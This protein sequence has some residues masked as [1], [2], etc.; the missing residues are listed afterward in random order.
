MNKKL[1]EMEKRLMVKHYWSL[2]E[3]NE[4][5]IFVD[6]KLH[7][8]E[9][10]PNKQLKEFFDDAIEHFNIGPEY[11]TLTMEQEM[12]K[13]LKNNKNGIHDYELYKNKNFKWSESFIRQHKDLIDFK[14]LGYGMRKRNVHYSMNLYR[15]IADQKDVGEFIASQARV[16]DCYGKYEIKEI[17]PEFKAKVAKKVNLDLIKEFRKQIYEYYSDHFGMQFEDLR[18]ELVYI[19]KLGGVII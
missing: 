1:T 3:D 2:L 8:R 6:W 14:Q 5:E 11:I 12:L 7:W 18:K 4:L 19:F 13:L 10:N 15:E 17:T 9:N 16:N